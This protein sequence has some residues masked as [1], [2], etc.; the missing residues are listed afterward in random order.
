M[1]QHRPDFNDTHACTDTMKIAIV[2]AQWNGDI[3]SALAQGARSRLIALG[4]RE[5]NILCV[6]VPGAIEL[7]YAA[8][9]L[10]KSGEYDAVIVF[11]CVERGDTPHFDYVC[12]SVTQ[13]VTVLNAQALTPVIFG[14]LTVENHQ[15]ALDRVGGP[16]G[17]K[18]V[19]AADTAV[20]MVDFKRSH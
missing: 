18:G 10:V 19:E 20:A 4:V 6:D 9:T 8:A 12:Q 11:G 15:Q 5:Q 1:S 3:T 13:G 14:V 7:T 16:A 2:R 17:H